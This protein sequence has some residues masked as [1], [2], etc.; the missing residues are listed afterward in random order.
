MLGAADP[1]TV[2]A[3][4]RPVHAGA[5]GPATAHALRMLATAFSVGAGEEPLEGK[6]GPGLVP[7]ETSASVADL[8]KALAMPVELVDVAPTL[9]PGVR[10]CASA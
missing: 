2:V 4:K 8:A 9:P 7:S 1:E 3:E 6:A 5:D 10:N